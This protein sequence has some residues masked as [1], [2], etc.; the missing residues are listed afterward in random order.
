MKQEKGKLAGATT[1]DGY[2]V[3]DLRYVKA[4]SFQSRGHGVIPTLN[5]E[6][7]GLFSQDEPNVDG[8]K[9]AGKLP[10]WA[11][12]TGD[13]P[14]WWALA[15]G[16]VDEHEPEVKELAD[17]ILERPQLHNVGIVPTEPND[18]GKDYDVV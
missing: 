8:R 18:T 5:A 13:S 1:A 17:S 11:M 16:L 6:G 15:V 2:F 14:D 10:L 12:L 9:S 3:L 7:H 4:N